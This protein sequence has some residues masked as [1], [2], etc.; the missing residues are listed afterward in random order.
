M[1]FDKKRFN[2]F[3]GPIFFMEAIL[4]M[5][6]ACFVL[7][8]FMP[9]SQID[10]VRPPFFVLGGMAILCLLLGVL[11]PLFND[12]RNEKSEFNVDMISKRL[13]TQKSILFKKQ[14]AISQQWQTAKKLAEI[15][16]SWAD[17]FPS[18]LESSSQ[19]ENLN[20]AYAK[21]NELGLD[22]EH[23]AYLLAM[24]KSSEFN[25]NKLDTILNEIKNKII[26]LQNELEFYEDLDER[27][28]WQYFKSKKWLKK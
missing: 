18:N 9:D 11:I 27:T 10:N 26:E 20:N 24:L 15:G 3:W 13:R 16:K 4:A 2:E 23:G 6:G 8:I 28:Y 14:F 17:L 5:I 25:F 1:G 19:K 12:K 21:F 7:A 22:T